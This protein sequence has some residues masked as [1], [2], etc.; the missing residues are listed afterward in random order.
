MCLCVLG[1]DNLRESAEICVST[2]HS[3]MCFHNL[4]RSQ[5]GI[6]FLG[7]RHHIASQVHKRLT[8]YRILVQ[9]YGRTLVAVLANALDDRDLS[10]QR[11]VQFFCQPLR[12]FLAEPTNP[13]MGTFTLSFIY[14]LIPLRASANATSWGVLTMTAPVIAKV[15]NK[16]R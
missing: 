2:K 14:I 13:R 16:V 7:L 5:L 4:R 9:R 15:C 12:A 11:H 1:G 3:L 6:A 10:Q 8:G